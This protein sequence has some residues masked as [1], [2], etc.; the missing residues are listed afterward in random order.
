MRK[1]IIEGDRV[2]YKMEPQVVKANTL[3]KSSS[4]HGLLNFVEVPPLPV[5]LDTVQDYEM[6]ISQNYAT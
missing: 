2:R 3:L 6:G 4:Q 5:F 1:G